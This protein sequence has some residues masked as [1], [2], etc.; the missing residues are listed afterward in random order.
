MYSNSYRSA[1]DSSLAWDTMLG[2]LAE[3][4][5]DRAPGVMDRIWLLAPDA[6]PE[7][8][9]S[10]LQQADPEAMVRAVAEANPE[11][12][13]STLDRTEPATVAAAILLTLERA[14]A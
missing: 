6:T 8:M 13:L 3:A 9:F 11:L 12:D 7:S 5:E 14:A 1:L 10:S 2:M 4:M